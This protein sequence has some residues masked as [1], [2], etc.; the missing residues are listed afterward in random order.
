[1]SQTNFVQLE[2]EE[3]AYLLALINEMDSETRYTAKQRAYTIPKLEGI[4]KDPATKRLCFQDVEY[5]LD[6]LEDDDVPETEQ[7]RTEIVIKLEEILAKQQ[8][9]FEAM[10]S[11]DEQRSAR[12]ARRNPVAA[13]QDHFER[14]QE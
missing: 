14:T 13:L 8:E 7:Q 11:I 6:L 2:A 10:R 9:A 12:K 3:C 1:M 5:L 4:A